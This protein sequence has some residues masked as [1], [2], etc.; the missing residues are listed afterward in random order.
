ME[1]IYCVVTIHV[2]ADKATEF[3]NLAHECVAGASAD[4]AGTEFYEW[5]IDESGRNALVL[6]A[7]DDQAAIMVHARLVGGSV[8][9]VLEVARFELEFFGDVPQG[10]LDR[11]AERLGSVRHFGR[12]VAGLLTK[13]VPHRERSGAEP[14]YALARFPID[15]ANADRMRELAAS[16]LARVAANEP[17]TLAYEWFVNGDGSEFVALDIYRNEAAL[18]QHNVKDIME[19]I[20]TLCAPQ[21]TMWGN[22][23]D[24]LKNQLTSRGVVIAGR[25]ID[26]II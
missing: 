22:L 6:E 2:S 24:T 18:A 14:I 8:G 17:G 19:E 3:E 23:S 26:G 12:R 4:L 10:I 21:I 16:A 1:K 11:M 7:Y 20:R 13:P 9:K 15:P 25:R 5:F